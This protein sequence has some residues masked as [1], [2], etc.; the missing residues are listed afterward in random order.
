MI[1]YCSDILLINSKLSRISTNS[2]GDIELDIPSDQYHPSTCYHEL[3][4][5]DSLYNRYYK[6]VD[7]SNLK[8]EFDGARVAKRISKKCFDEVKE[9]IEKGKA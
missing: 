5:Y 3:Y 2:S 9:A 6:Y 1:S 4:Y 7:S 8:K